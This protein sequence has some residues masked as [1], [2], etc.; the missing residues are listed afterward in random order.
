LSAPGNAIFTTADGG[1]YG[2]WYGTC[3]ATPWVSGT[4]ALIMSV[5]SNLTPSQVK[6]ILKQSAD[7]LGA[8]GWDSG[9]GWG[10][11]NA[12]RAV[13]LAMTYSSPSPPPP[14]P[15]TIS[16]TVTITSPQNGV[17]VGN[18]TLSIYVNASDNVEVAK[19]ELY[20]DGKLTSTSNLAPFTTKWNTRKATRGAHT[21]QCKA[22][23]AAGNVTTS[24]ALTLYK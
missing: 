14:S 23:D 16:P 7:D 24:G 18:T 2:V 19:V 20:V 5:N 4:A 17:T 11:V 10:R 9:Y 13:N 15:D 3:F 1:G 6:D 12:S 8:S 21:L 22:Y